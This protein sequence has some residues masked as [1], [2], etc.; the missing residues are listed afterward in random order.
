MS[1]LA[2]SDYIHYFISNLSVFP[3]FTNTSGLPDASYFNKHIQRKKNGSNMMEAFIFFHVKCRTQVLE[4]WLAF[5]PS[6]SQGHRN[7]YPVVLP[8]SMW[9]PRSGF[10]FTKLRQND[11]GQRGARGG[12]V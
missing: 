7:P 10:I 6:S 3:S 9:L 12:V 5:F 2:V 4:F 8:S 1:D 11:K